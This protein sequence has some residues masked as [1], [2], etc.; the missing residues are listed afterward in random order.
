MLKLPVEYN[1][2]PD[3]LP[4]LAALALLFLIVFGGLYRRYIVSVFDPLFVFTFTTAFAS[5]LVVEVLKTPS[6]IIHFFVCQLC[7]FAGFASVRPVADITPTGPESQPAH[8]VDRLRLMLYG[9]LGLY[10]A[11][12]L[13]VFSVNG[14]P[15][16]SPVPTSAKVAYFKDGFGLVRKINW[17]IGGFLITG[18]LYLYLLEK[19]RLYLMGLGLV[20]VGLVFEGSKSSLLRIIFAFTLLVYHP[21]LR[22]QTRLLKSFRR[23]IPY[24]IGALAVVFL[25][26]LSRENNGLTSALSAFLKR[27]LYSGDPVLYYYLPVNQIHFAEYGPADYLT[28]VTNQITGFLRLTPYWDA[29]GNVM[30]RNILPP[31]TP[32]DQYVGPNTPFYIEGQIFFGYFGAFI[33]SGILGV[34]VGGIRRMYFRYRGASAFWFIFLCYLCQ[35]ATTL[36]IDTRMGVGFLFDVFVFILPVYW[37]MR[38]VTGYFR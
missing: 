27:L 38:L 28:Y 21:L 32:P 35:I 34:L 26:I 20:A 37:V 36:F 23:F 14:I 1:V 12:N 7:L 4:R 29:F 11:A 16:L 24:G 2:I 10:I 8:E 5:V 19:K 15:L 18:L 30:L 22:S 9:F 3:A 31:G 33:L 17:T 13:I 25:G 6:P